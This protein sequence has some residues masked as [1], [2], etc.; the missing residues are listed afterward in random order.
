ME[1]DSEVNIPSI[2]DIFEGVLVLVKWTCTCEEL[3]GILS[4]KLEDADKK[5]EKIENQIKN[6]DP[7][8]SNFSSDDFRTGAGDGMILHCNSDEHCNNEE[9]ISLT[10]DERVYLIYH[11]CNI[12]YELA[13]EIETLLQ[14]SFLE[15]INPHGC[16]GDVDYYNVYLLGVKLGLPFNQAKDICSSIAFM[17]KKIKSD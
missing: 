7:R 13:Q 9:S 16:G 17:C 12:A 11:R 8:V 4:K 15:K 5:L 10:R 14:S 2:S 3:I 6:L 1:L